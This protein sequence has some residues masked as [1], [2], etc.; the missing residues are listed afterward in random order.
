[1]I[2]PTTAPTKFLYYAHTKRSQSNMKQGI[3]RKFKAS[4]CPHVHIYYEKIISS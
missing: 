2:K 4:A 1:M 3:L